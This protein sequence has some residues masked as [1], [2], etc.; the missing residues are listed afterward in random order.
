MSTTSLTNLSTDSSAR[1]SIA[2]LCPNDDERAEQRE[3]S[4]LKSR[5]EVLPLSERCTPI[6]SASSNSHDLP[7]NKNRRR[8]NTV[9]NLSQDSAFFR[10]RKENLINTSE[11]PSNLSQDSTRH[12]KRKIQRTDSIHLPDDPAFQIFLSKLSGPRSDRLN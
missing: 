6:S 7:K 12:K 3:S 10:K 8:T 11:P 9:H 2:N 4:P 5:P 1:I